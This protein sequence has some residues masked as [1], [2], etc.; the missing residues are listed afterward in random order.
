MRRIS[1]VS[2]VLAAS[3]LA[4]CA[5]S[6]D[7]VGQGSA[8][9]EQPPPAAGGENERLERRLAHM[10]DRLELTDEQ[11]A[12]IRPIFERMR[13]ERQRV[14]DLPNE[15][16]RE[17]MRALHEQMRT[18]LEG[19]LTPEQL[20]EAETMRRGFGR[21]GRHGRRGGRHGDFGQRGA[22]ELPSPDRIV[23]RMQEHLELS[24]AQVAQVR[25]IVERNHQRFGELREL[26]R[27]ER[28]AAMQTL[29]EE[30]RTELTQVLTPEQLER[31][32]ARFGRR[33]GGER[34]MRGHRGRDHGSE[35]VE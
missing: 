26:P 22:H 1:T 4:A 28:R 5:A 13:A 35:P 16:R 11:V 33:F 12:L 32:E 19:V 15:E 2:L 21:H 10:K 3:L 9:V 6:T 34:G 23:E 30:I 29:R 20:A 8:T 24:E 18:E 27:D 17:A 25:P 7:E 14:R 31:L